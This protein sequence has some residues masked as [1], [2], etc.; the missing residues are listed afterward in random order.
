MLISPAC[1][2]GVEDAPVIGGD[3]LVAG[4]GR[5]GSESAVVEKGTVDPVTEAEPEFRAVL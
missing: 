2:F 3:F 1:C 4:Q 5:G